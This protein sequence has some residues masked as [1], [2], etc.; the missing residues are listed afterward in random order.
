MAVDT[1]GPSTGETM[2]TWD[3]GPDKFNPG[4][5][6]AVRHGCT[7]PVLDNNHGRGIVGGYGG[8]K[9]RPAFWINGN[10]E[11]HVSPKG[12]LFDPVV[13]WPEDP[14]KPPGHVVTASSRSAVLNAP[15]SKPP[16]SKVRIYESDSWG[17][18]RKQLRYEYDWDYG[19]MFLKRA[20]AFGS[21]TDVPEA[22]LWGK[23]IHAVGSEEGVP[24]VHLRPRYQE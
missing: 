12:E 17:R 10:C 19:F 3:E 9:F 4:S 15:K 1:F 22:R 6:D 8:T 13:T 24:T 11:Y 18:R 20:L 14:Q 23:V 21:A 16:S 7:C 5:D 2:P